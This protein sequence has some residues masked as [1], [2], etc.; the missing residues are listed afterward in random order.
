VG[1]PL[2]VTKDTASCDVLKKYRAR[3][4]KRVRRDYMPMRSCVVLVRGSKYPNVD[5]EMVLQLY[6]SAA[7][8]DCYRLSTITS[9]QLAQDVLEMN[10]DRFLCDEQ[11]F[12]D[13][14]VPVAGSDVT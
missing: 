2:V 9:A 4:R 12:C 3:V 5:A 6:D 10:L 8:A 7:D 14:P 13:I 11:F 1:R